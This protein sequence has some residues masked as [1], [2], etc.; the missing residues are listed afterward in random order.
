[1]YKPPRCNNCEYWREK[2]VKRSNSPKEL[3]ECK[4]TTPQMGPNGYGYWP[5]T[6]GD[7]FCYYG[8]HIVAPMLNES[9]TK[10]M[11]DPDGSYED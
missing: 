10:V 11:E 6:S 2:P 4:A 1:M 7:D 3:G 8:K 9:Q 5:L